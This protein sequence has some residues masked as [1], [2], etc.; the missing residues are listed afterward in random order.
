MKLC[1]HLYIFLF[2]LLLVLN[3]LVALV[4]EPII[5]QFRITKYFR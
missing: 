1:D 2:D 4:D 5:K 3:L